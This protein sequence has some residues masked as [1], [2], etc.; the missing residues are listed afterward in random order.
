MVGK[1]HVHV[2]EF[3]DCESD[4]HNLATEVIIWDVGGNQ[5]GGS[6]YPDSRTQRRLCS[7]QSWNGGIQQSANVSDSTP[8]VQYWWLGSEARCGLY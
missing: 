3:E 4:K 6:T 1:C 2:N 7:V 5:I 8:V